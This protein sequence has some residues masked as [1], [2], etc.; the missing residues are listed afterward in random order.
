MTRKL[1]RF[2]GEVDMNGAGTIRASV[3]GSALYD[4]PLSSKEAKILPRLSMGTGRLLPATAPT[5][6]L[7]RTPTA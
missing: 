7:S 6:W 1:A 4:A 5:I 2:M 3:F